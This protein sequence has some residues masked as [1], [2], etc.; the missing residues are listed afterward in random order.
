[1]KPAKRAATYEDLCKVP[2]HLVAEIIDGELITSPRPASPHALAASGIGSDLWTRFNRPPGDPE[3]PGGWWILHEPELHLGPDVIVPDLAG[4]RRERMPSLPN[5]AAFTLAPDWACE[6]V[7]PSTGW[8]DRG[9]KMRIYA[10]EGVRHLWMVDPI[11][12]TV[13]VY[14]LE[15]DRWI[16]AATHG[17]A[18]P[19]RAEPFAE[20]ELDVSRWW[21]EGDAA[22]GG[23]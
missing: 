17:G 6:V 7:S 10:R 15:G 16:V 23:E 3:S 19:M 2:E 14:R 22:V 11:A 21:L 18:G 9:R 5:V 8:I 20:V 1:M 4:W 13:E 12:R